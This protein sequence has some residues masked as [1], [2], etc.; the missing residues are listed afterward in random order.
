MVFRLCGLHHI[1]TT[2]K[3]TVAALQHHSGTTL[4]DTGKEK[5]SQGREAQT[6]HIIIQFV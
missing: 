5:S 1:G 2:Q 3:W 6:V 4:K